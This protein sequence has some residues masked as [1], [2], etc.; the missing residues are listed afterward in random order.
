MDR[1][2]HLHHSHGLYAP[3]A[4]P[5]SS[6]GGPMRGSFLARD[7]AGMDRL[8]RFNKAKEEKVNTEFPRKSLI[9]VHC[10]SKDLCSNVFFQVGV[11]AKGRNFVF[12]TLSPPKHKEPEEEEEVG[13]PSPLPAS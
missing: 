11:G 7:A 9:T 6:R 10:S 13:S 8:E 12:A 5:N 4:P 1:M 3:P 2:H